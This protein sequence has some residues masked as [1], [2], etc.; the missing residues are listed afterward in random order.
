M[1]RIHVAVESVV[2]DGYFYE[3]SLSLFTY[4]GLFVILNRR[5]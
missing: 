4:S 1:Y 2:T 5:T 3:T